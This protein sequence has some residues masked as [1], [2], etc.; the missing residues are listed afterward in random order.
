MLHRH[1]PDDVLID[2]AGRCLCPAH[3]P[4]D[5]E[6]APGVAPCGCQWVALPKAGGRLRRV[7]LAI[8]TCDVVENSQLYPVTVGLVLYLQ[9]GVS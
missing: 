5:C 4:Q 1:H 9:F 3:G 7:R 8:S 6:Y 2:L